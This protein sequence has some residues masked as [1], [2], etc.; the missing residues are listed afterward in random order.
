[1]AE[2]VVELQAVEEARAVVEAEDVLGEQIAVAVD[3]PA[4]L[5]PSVE[6]RPT[7]RQIATYQPLHLGH[8]LRQA[9]VPGQLPHLPETV[10][11]ARGQRVPGPLL[12][13]LR[14]PGRPGVPGRELPGDGPQDV[15]DGRPLPHQAGETA[16]RGHPAH[17]HERL[18]IP[19]AG[20][21]QLAEPQVDV[22]EKRR[23]SSTSRSH[24]VRRACTAV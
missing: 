13:H 18:R 11:P 15:V 16:V 4:L 22:G 14:T 5:D 20:L 2:A 12:V 1:M 3:H 19:V 10:L 23:L 6:Q 9:A 24:A 21:A 17:H 7:A 8:L